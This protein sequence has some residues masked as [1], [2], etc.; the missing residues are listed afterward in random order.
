MKI[1]YMVWGELGGMG[2]VS[3]LWAYDDVYDFYRRLGFEPAGYDNI[4][5]R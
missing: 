5:K 1:T 3:R 4:Y 2:S